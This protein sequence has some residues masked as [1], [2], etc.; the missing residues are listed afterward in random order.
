MA[1][2]SPAA[3]L[4]EHTCPEQLQRATLV[5]P[6]LVGMPVKRDKCPRC[7][8]S[9]DG[10]A[11]VCR[12]CYRATVVMPTGLRNYVQPRK[13]TPEAKVAELLATAERRDGCL[14][15][16]VGAAWEGYR[17]VNTT[18]HNSITAHR[19]LWEVTHGVRL[20]RGMVV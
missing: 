16:T 9:K 14:I 13:A 8:A 12:E 19:L 3:S 11:A 20:P 4:Q 10:R 17:R 5:R 15:A 18:E 2:L 1:T 7:G 6:I